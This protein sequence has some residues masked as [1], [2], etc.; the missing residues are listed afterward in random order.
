[1][2]NLNRREFLKI[3]IGSAASTAIAVSVAPSFLSIVWSKITSCFKKRRIE[4]TIAQA[5]NTPE[6]RIALAQSMVEPIRRNLEYQAIGRKL[7]M[8]KE[9]PT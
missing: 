1:M 7:L 4:R 8:V 9:L 3:F 6:G 2:S 5:L